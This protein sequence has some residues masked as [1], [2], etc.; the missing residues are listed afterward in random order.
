MFYLIKGIKRIIT[1]YVIGSELSKLILELENK[2]NILDNEGLSDLYDKILEE[3]DTKTTI[4]SNQNL[5]VTYRK[6]LEDKLLLGIIEPIIESTSESTTEPIIESTS[7]STT[8]PIIESISESKTELTT[9]SLIE[10]KTETNMK[11]N[12]KVELSINKVNINK[13]KSKYSNKFRKISIQQNK[14]ICFNCGRD[15][16]KQNECT[17]STDIY[18]LLLI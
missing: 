4:Y 3:Y 15:T 11:K 1:D 13:K 10:S 9:E 2:K 6:T 14:T 12:A 18:G 5:V 7:E 16:H 8:E 17:E